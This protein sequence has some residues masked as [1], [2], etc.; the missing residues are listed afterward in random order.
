M[1]ATQRSLFDATEGTAETRREAGERIAPFAHDQRGAVLEFVR[2]QGRRGAI[3]QVI[4]EALRICPD[5]A[6]ARRVEL[7]QGG[8]RLVYTRP[9]HR[10]GEAR[11]ST[12][13]ATG[14]T[15]VGIVNGARGSPRGG[16]S[17][18]D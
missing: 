2:A 7:V 16:R 11:R 4:T 13:E 6:R 18:T 17:V 9:R 3:D 15:D 12:T 8:D 10:A 14:S 1:T 5:S